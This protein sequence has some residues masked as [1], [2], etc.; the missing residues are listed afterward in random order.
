MAKA[1]VRWFESGRN[2]GFLGTVVSA[3]VAG[4]VL[5]ALDVAPVAKWLGSAWRWVV[6]PV[7]VPLIALVAMVGG[8]L[9]AIG[10]WLLRRLEPA[11]PAWLEYRADTFLGINWRW[12]YLSDGQMKNRSLSAFCPSCHTRLRAEVHGYSQMTT[13]FICDECHFR[14]DLPGNSDEIIDRICRLI[15]RE[16]NRKA[17]AASTP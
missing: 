11:P 17:R 8:L 4:F 6:H 10:G 5:D 12:D 3:I 13:S 1:N 14:Q 9:V 15:E 2:L 7:P 16:A